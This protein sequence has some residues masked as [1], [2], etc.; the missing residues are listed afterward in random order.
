MYVNMVNDRMVKMIDAI[1]GCSV[2]TNANNITITGII[3]AISNLTNLFS[4]V[5][6]LERQSRIVLG[7]WFE[8]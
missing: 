7:D 6:I 1:N 5:L 8:L 2:T 4:M 3:N